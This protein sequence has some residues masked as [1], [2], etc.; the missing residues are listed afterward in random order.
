MKQKIF[1]VLFVLLATTASAQEKD[2]ALWLSAGAKAALNNKFAL[3]VEGVMRVNDNIS[4]L[5]KGYVEAELSYDLNKYFELAFGYRYEST[6]ETELY[7]SNEHDLIGDLSLDYSWNRFSFGMRNRYQLK[8]KEVFSSEKGMLADNIYRNRISVE[9]NVKG[10][11]IAPYINYELFYKMNR[12]E[13]RLIN[14]Q[15]F[16]L[17]IA[18]RPKKKHKFK[19]YYLVED[20]CNVASPVRTNV[21]G[22]DYTFYFKKRTKKSDDL[23]DNL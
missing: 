12:F 20:E 2:L 19:V 14:K 23:D 5:R 15:R 16:A 11:K 8:Y 1:A 7:Y 17:G 9:Y 3:S 18:Y 10:I 4:R 6:N 22:V 21:I 13:E